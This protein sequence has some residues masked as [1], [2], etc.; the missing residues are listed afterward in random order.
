MNV[1]EIFNNARNDPDLLSTIDIEELL[2]AVE[3]DKNKHL[4]NKTLDDI[5]QEKYE[6]LKELAKPNKISES[7]PGSKS[8]A[9]E[10]RRPL[11]R[12]VAEGA[13]R[14]TIGVQPALLGERGN[15][16]DVSR[17]SSKETIK[18]IFSKLSEYRYVDEIFQLHRGKH[19]RWI[20]R[21]K[22]DTLTNGGIVMD[23]KFLDTG[24]HILTKNGMNRFIQYNFDDCI[25]FQ[26]MSSEEQMILMAYSKIQAETQD[27]T[28]DNTDRKEK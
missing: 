13:G 8:T 6:Q 25:T 28:Q 2:N 27:N 17:R 5:A 3:N 11:E 22:P 24:T 7:F 20:R 9:F 16:G 4:D 18:T 14:N 21:D 23:V 19:I 10:L 26:K 12:P 15:S 1:Q